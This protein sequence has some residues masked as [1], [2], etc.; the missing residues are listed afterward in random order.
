MEAAKYLRLLWRWWWVVAQAVAL[1]AAGAYLLSRRATPVYESSV[2]LL[3]NQ[4][5]STSFTPTYNDVLKGEHLA[6]TYAELM[7]KRPVLDPVIQQLGLATDANALA[8]RVRVAAVRDTLLIVVSVED[9][10][11]AR[12]AMVANTIADVFVQQN[13][14]LQAERY[15]ALNEG[16][17]RELAGEQAEIDRLQTELALLTRNVLRDELIVVRSA[18][19]RAQASLASQD[20]QR[21]VLQFQLAEIRDEI[22]RLQTGRDPVVALGTNEQIALQSELQTRLDQHR[23]NY[24][25]L[26]RSLEEVRLAESQTSDFLSIVEPAAPSSEPVRPR[27][28]L[29]VLMVAILAGLATL[30]VAFLVELFD[31]SV[32]SRDDVEQLA[33]LPPVAAVGRIGGVGLP[34]KLVAARAT[35]SAAAEAYNML[36]TNLEF[37]QVDRPISTLLVTSPGQNEGKSTTAANLAIAIARTDRRVVLVDLDLRQPSLHQFFKVNNQ[38]GVTTALL[39]PDQAVSEYLL[40]TGVENLSLIPSGPLPSNPAE[41]LG[42][43]RIAELIEELKGEADMVIFDSSPA[44]AVAD[45]T[46][47]AHRCDATL[48]VA[49]AG[50]TRVEALRRVRDQLAGAGVRLLGV[51]LNRVSGS[52]IGRRYYRRR[53]VAIRPAATPAARDL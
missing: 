44:L 39:H 4:A 51:V 10:D 6:K 15:T 23:S 1:A 37:A 12:A 16:L 11:P 53:A 5:P 7:D 46:L 34:S 9:E 45:A 49:R 2:S 28:L 19:D 18:V 36:R 30:G 22:E 13:R 41:L 27:V 14:D 38:R 20:V 52:A 43:R 40:P 31:N 29:N 35:G 21:Q 32:R 24:E 26:L 50:A 3:I 17:Q 47:I 8:D 48:L 42:S 25:S 33:G